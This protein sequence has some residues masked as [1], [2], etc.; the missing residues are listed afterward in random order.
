MK[1]ETKIEIGIP[2]TPAISTELLLIG[3][4]SLIIVN[5]NGGIGGG[6]QRL[7]CQEGLT[8]KN[9]KML[10]V[11]LT[12]SKRKLEINEAWI[13]SMENVNL[14]RQTHVHQNE[15][16]GPSPMITYFYAK[17]DVILTQGHGRP[18]ARLNKH[19]MYSTVNV[20]NC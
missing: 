6:S 1:T 4:R 20:E 5:S 19:P 2:C 11:E 10:K 3:P 17:G 16:M 13:S 8:P 15:N 9:S 12:E 7:V 18:S 14:Y